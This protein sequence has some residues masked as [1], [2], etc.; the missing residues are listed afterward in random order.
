[1]TLKEYIM[2]PYPNGVISS[3]TREVTRAMYKEKFEKIM[4]REAGTQ[5]PVKFYIGK[6]SWFIHLKVPSEAI[7]NFTYDVV[8]EF[9][10]VKNSV[11]LEECETKFYS[12]DPA[13]VYTYA[14]TFKS[15]KMFCDELSSRMPKEA[16]RTKAHEKNPSN[17]VGYVKSLYFGYLL[18]KTK[19]YLNRTLFESRATGYSRKQL[20]QN[21]IPADLKIAQR[22]S[23]QDEINKAK[24]IEKSKKDVYNK[25]SINQVLNP[26]VQ[27]GLKRTRNISTTRTVK[28]SNNRKSSIRKTKRI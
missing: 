20:E 28:S 9:L 26:E 2:N 8:F 27:T 17:I 14:N 24:R 13:F 15:H 7:P 1:M 4:L 19:N 12:N 10:N 11:N 16:L 21:I 18:C 6:S 25:N 5:L 3:Q 23:A 22:Q